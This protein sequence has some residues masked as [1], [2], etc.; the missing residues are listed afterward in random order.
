MARASA[1]AADTLAMLLGLQG[2]SVQVARD[3]VAAVELTGS[4]R[5]QILLLDL[6]MPRLDGYA[7][8]KAIRAE[9]WGADI[10]IVA[11]T[12]YTQP[13]DRARARDAGIDQ[14]VVKPVEIA[15]LERICQALLAGAV[16]PRSLA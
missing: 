5:P 12:G 16:Q 9:P 4:F 1:D 13:S 10:H 15:V 3:G 11:L 14:F 6:G 7:T 8:A 2:H